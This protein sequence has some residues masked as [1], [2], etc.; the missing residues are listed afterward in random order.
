MTRTPDR[1][2]DVTMVAATLAPLILVVIILI[3]LRQAW[4]SVTHFG[5]G[6][7]TSRDWNPVT[8]QFGAWPGIFGT[9]ATSL[10]ALAIALPVGVAAAVVLAEQGQQAVRGAA[11]TGI[12]LLAAIPSVVYGI[13]ALYV[14][15]PWTYQHISG[16][17]SDRFSNVTWLSD[18]SPRS[19]FTA[20]LVL[21]VMI[22]PTLTAVSRDVIRSIPRGLRENAVALGATWWETTWGVIL[23]SARAGIFG[24]TILALGR[25]LGETIAVTM[26]IGNNYQVP[27]SI[28]SPAYTLASVIANEF[29]EAT[30]PFHLSSLFVVAFWLLIVSLI[31]NTVGKLI[32][33]RTAEGI[34]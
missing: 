24:A 18:A 14:L 22:L 21:A 23:P 9:V 20:G 7:L 27:P 13:W 8:L 33:G 3:L 5:A 16:P 30:E 25:A 34:A 17:I 11:G 10:L 1:F 31:V 4:P 26:V 12:E 19:L 15:G 29:T 6:F 32:V 2:R 28:F